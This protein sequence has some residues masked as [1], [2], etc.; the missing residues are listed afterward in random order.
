TTLELMKLDVM[1]PELLVDINGVDPAGTRIE[2]RANALFLGAFV[3]MAEASEHPEIRRNYPLVAQSLALAASPQIRN[4]ATLG[5][6][7]LQRTRCP[8]FRDPSA[9]ACNRRE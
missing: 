9:G 5:G 6:N 7:V 3:T 2:R 4:M 1:Q 8:Y